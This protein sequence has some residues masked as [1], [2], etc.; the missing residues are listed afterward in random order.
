MARIRACRPRRAVEAVM[1]PQKGVEIGDFLIG[2]E[3]ERDT[4]RPTHDPE[5]PAADRFAGAQQ[6]PELGWLVNGHNGQ[7]R[8]TVQLVAAEI[9]AARYAANGAGWRDRRRAPT[10]RS[11][12]RSG[13]RKARDPRTRAAS[14]RRHR[15]AGGRRN[16]TDAGA[17]SVPPSAPCCRRPRSTSRSALDRHRWS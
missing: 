5:V 4:R 9:Q 3:R 1:G 2:E 6:M 15:R 17:E 11:S 7:R 10:H 8:P 16:P 12:S 13:R 14:R